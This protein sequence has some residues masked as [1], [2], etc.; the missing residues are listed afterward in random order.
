[1]SE[2]DPKAPSGAVPP[3]KRRVVRSAQTAPDGA[4]VAGTEPSGTAVESAPKPSEVAA[5]PPKAPLP[6]PAPLPAVRVESRPDGRRFVDARAPRGGS[7][8]MEPRQP[9]RA[10]QHDEATRAAELSMPRRPERTRDPSFNRDTRPEGFRRPATSGR[11]PTQQGIAEPRLTSDMNG[12]R[13][14]AQS[15]EQREPQKQPERTRRTEARPA[16]ARAPE[17]L[18]AQEAPPPAPPKE[19]DANAEIALA[20]VAPVKLKQAVVAKK[21][22]PKTGKEALAQRARDPKHGRRKGGGPTSSAAARSE[23]QSAKGAARD[24]GDESP[25]SASDVDADA[26]LEIPKRP[27]L[28][29]RVV[30]IF[31]RSK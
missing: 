30:S 2:E 11:S 22:K 29:Q 20:G 3:I 14:S 25:D 23:Q 4:A 21:D 18:A 26:E 17:R 6:A 15:D 28:W 16:A 12:E 31:K 7:R 10:R 24:A 13:T 9:D 19:P 5:P 27:S 1:M 8:P